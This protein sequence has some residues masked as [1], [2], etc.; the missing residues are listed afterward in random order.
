MTDATA[1]PD[2]G[3]TAA[4]V[5]AVVL[6]VRDEQLTDPTPCEGAPVGQ[7]LDHLAGL[8][9]AFRH[10]AAKTGGEITRNAPQASIGHLDPAWRE[11]LPG[12]LDELAAAW[13]EPGAW[14]GDAQAGGVTLPASV[15]GLVALNEL[16]I[17]G[18]D[19]A[20]ATGQPYQPERAALEAC[21]AVYPDE[22]A[23][24]S[25][26]MFGPRVPVPA[27]APLLDRVV[28]LSG[29]DPHWTP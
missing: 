9:V 17:H 23:G 11:K 8:T 15:M 21:T 3:P 4:A 20:V 7:L 25:P 27:G 12:R 10:S 13:R 26:G 1:R 29:R 22:Q 28:G 24:G 6:G 16:L 14:E 19:V 5:K 18:W 2:L